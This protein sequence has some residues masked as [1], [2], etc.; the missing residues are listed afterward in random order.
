MSGNNLSHIMFEKD[1]QIA[2]LQSSLDQSEQD[3][4][5]L[6]EQVTDLQRFVRSNEFHHDSFVH[7]FI[8]YSIC[9][10]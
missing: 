7:V 9:C 5:K 1:H 6:S 2:T 4:M 8:D 10:E 3:K